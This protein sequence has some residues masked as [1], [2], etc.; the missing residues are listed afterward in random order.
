MKAYEFI[1]V[2]N[3]VDEATISLEDQLFEA[4]C[5]DALLFFKDGTV[6]LAFTR[7]SESLE[8]AIFSA[9][10]A[11][12]SMV[13]PIKVASVL[14]EALV[15]VSEIAQRIGKGRQTVSLWAK[16]ARNKGHPFPDPV[17]GVAAKRPLWRWYEVACW[18]YRQHWVEQEVIQQAQIIE[19]INAALLERDPSIKK[20]RELATKVLN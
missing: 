3:G 13:L 15:G 14:P 19:G 2:L 17:M 8:T 4:G 9:I 6:F 12:E 5:D 16:R 20:I 7:K 10:H 18:L 11:V 1:L